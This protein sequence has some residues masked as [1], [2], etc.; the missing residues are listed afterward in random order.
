MQFNDSIIDDYPKERTM[1]ATCQLYEFWGNEGIKN[2][3][4][5]PKF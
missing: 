2:I 5:G 3:E 4:I 1:Q